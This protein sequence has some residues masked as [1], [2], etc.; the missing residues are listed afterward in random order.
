[1]N[2]DEYNAKV[3][4]LQAMW[5]DKSRV[6]PSHGVSDKLVA[7]YFEVYWDGRWHQLG[8][9]RNPFTPGASYEWCEGDEI[10]LCG[11]FAAALIHS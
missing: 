5:G 10:R 11:E 9:Q 2:R 7:A 4:E 1:M 6:M 3:Q 8:C